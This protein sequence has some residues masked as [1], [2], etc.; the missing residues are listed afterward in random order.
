[1][2]RPAAKFFRRAAAGEEERGKFS[3]GLNLEKEKTRQ[4]CGCRVYVC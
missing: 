1:M 2:S 3:S 4:P